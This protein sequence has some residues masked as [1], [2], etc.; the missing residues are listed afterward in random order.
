MIN[1]FHLLLVYLLSGVKPKLTSHKRCFIM[2]PAILNRQYL[3]LPNSVNVQIKA[4]ERNALKCL[5]ISF[6]WGAA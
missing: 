3:S 6:N 2:K 1:S 5:Q 4:K